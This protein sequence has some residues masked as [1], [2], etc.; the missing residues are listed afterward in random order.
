VSTSW[1]YRF[2][3][4][5]LTARHRFLWAAAIFSLASADITRLAGAAC[6][7]CSL[8]SEGAVALARRRLAQ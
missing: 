2:F 1:D 5:R 7:V 4:A 6:A 8:G 3:A